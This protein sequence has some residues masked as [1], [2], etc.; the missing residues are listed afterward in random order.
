MVA[1]MPE[2]W[3]LF[4]GGGEGG[5]PVYYFDIVIIIEMFMYAS[6][7]VDSLLRTTKQ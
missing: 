7:H 1:C 3:V 2:G 6:Y 4:G 5:F